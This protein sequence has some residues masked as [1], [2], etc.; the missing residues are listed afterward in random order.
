MF[1]ARVF[2]SHKYAIHIEFPDSKYFPSIEQCHDDIFIAPQFGVSNVTHQM[3]NL[4][5]IEFNIWT[6]QNS[7]KGFVPPV[8]HE[9]AQYGYQM[10]WTWGDYDNEYESVNVGY[11]SHIHYVGGYERANQFATKKLIY[12]FASKIARIEHEI[13]A[14]YPQINKAL[15]RYGMKK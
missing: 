13:L 12:S 9:S 5:K 10:Y 4:P 6:Y 15:E 2:T 3:L 14:Y 7:R 11:Y 1:T 8:Y